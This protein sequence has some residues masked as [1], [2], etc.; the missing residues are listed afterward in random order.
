MPALLFRFP[1]KNCYSSTIKK[2][3][4]RLING[5]GDDRNRT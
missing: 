4:Y 2:T 5:M 3:L 1:D